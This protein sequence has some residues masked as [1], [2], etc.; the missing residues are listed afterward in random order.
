MNCMVKLFA[1]YEEKSIGPGLVSLLE[2]V[3]N[4]PNVME[5]AAKINISYSKAW[6]LIKNAEKCLGKP[7]VIRKSGGPLGGEAGISEYAICFIQIFRKTEKQ[8]VDF[9]MQKFNENYQELMNE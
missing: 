3:Q 6:K 5:A 4:S 8:V 7:L 1:G 2:A 9:A